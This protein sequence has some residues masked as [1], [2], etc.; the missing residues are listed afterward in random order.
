MSTDIHSVSGMQFITGGN[1]DVLWITVLKIQQKAL[2][3]WVL[4]TVIHRQNDEWQTVAWWRKYAVSA[5]IDEEIKGASVMAIKYTEEQLN[6]VDKSLCRADV[7]EPAGTA[8]ISDSGNPF[9][10]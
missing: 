2:G 8:G 3:S 10:E 7:F 4:N 5:I 9:P 1:G 6:S